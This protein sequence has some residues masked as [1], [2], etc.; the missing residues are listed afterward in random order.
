MDGPHADQLYG[1][2]RCASPLAAHS[3]RVRFVS[4]RKS[5][6]TWKQSALMLLE[7]SRRIRILVGVFSSMPKRTSRLVPPSPLCGKL[8]EW[9]RGRGKGGKGRK[10]RGRGEGGDGRR[11]NY[12]GMD[13]QS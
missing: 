3:R 13:N 7:C 8:K 2:V 12:A 6:R 5:L 10:S 4:M 1:K 11:Y 9:R